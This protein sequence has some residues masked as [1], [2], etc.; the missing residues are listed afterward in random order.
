MKGPLRTTDRDSP[1]YR[2]E[3]VPVDP[4][5]ARL[6]EGFDPH[7]EPGIFPDDFLG[8]GVSE[9]GVHQEERNIRLVS[10]KTKP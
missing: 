6:L 8:V 3:R 7:L 2:H 4:R 9:E 1:G 5:V 10:D